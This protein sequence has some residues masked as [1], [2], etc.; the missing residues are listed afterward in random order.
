[1]GLAP[2]PFAVAVTGAAVFAVC[3]VA[4]SLG[5]RW[6]VDRV[7]LPRFAGADIDEGALAAGAAIVI[8]IGVVR[9]TGIVVRRGFAG[10]AEWRAAERLAHGL[11][12]RMSA[13]PVP[14]HRRHMV[15]DLVARC[16][17]DV[18]V[19]VGVMAP[20]PFSSSVVVMVVAAAGFLLATDLV[21]GGIATALLPALLAVN[22]VYQRRIDT[23]YVDAQ[24]ELGLLSEAVHESFDGVVVVKAFGAEDRETARL[25]R[26]AGRLRDAQ[27]RAVA[28]RS[29]F[30][31]LLDATPS[32]A[33][34][35]LLAVGALRVRDAAMTLGDLASVLYLFTL[36]A[37]P[38]RIIGHLLSEIPH[39]LAGWRRV[40]E[41][42]DAPIENDPRASI[43]TAD[44]ATPVVLSGVEVAHGAG[45]PVLRGVD[46]TLSAGSTTALVGATGCGKTTLLHA[47][48]GLVPVSAGRVGLAT[49]RVGLVFQEA[50]LFADSL[51]FNLTLGM[52][53][54]ETALWD[55]LEVADAAELVRELDNGLDTTL[56]ERG[57]GLS[58]GQRQRIALARALALGAE[59]L[60]LDDTTSA[61]DPGTEARVLANLRGMRRTVTTLVVAS[62][63]STIA[64]ADEV[65]H[66]RDGRVAARGTHESL[67]ARHRDYR[68]LMT[69]FE[70]ERGAERAEMRGA[71]P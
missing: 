4:S 39:S 25:A 33:N 36:L 55:A 45:A 42:V 61:L 53:V 28:V 69:A 31:A 13:Q 15:G 40:V 18:D 5:V 10:M 70:T 66:L 32:L 52:R 29:T 59:L 23:H 49:P 27:V 58:G 37:F 43:G 54:S 46:L 68:D 60:L 67:M 6:M 26:I 11:L 56:G 7:I 65:V 48:A 8:G 16:G 51:R 41:V 38:L 1:V 17:V 57:S 63:P 47:I 3:T 2:R 22:L 30:E 14:W 34:V 64:L 9:A 21:L 20:M 71:R 50:F 62:R 44:A 35:L 12:A 24:R 19:A